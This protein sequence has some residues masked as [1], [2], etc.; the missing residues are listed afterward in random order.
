MAL[1][2]WRLTNRTVV[3]ELLH[4]AISQNHLGY[5]EGEL[6]AAYNVMV[7]LFSAGGSYSKAY[8]KLGEI[9]SDTTGRYDEQIKEAAAALLAHKNDSTYK[10]PFM[11]TPESNAQ[12]DANTARKKA[13]TARIK[14]AGV[15]Q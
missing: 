3:H 9:V 4:W 15:F 11:G 12:R 2:R 13:S 5:L 8:K 7:N 6:P 1:V 10:P 14:S